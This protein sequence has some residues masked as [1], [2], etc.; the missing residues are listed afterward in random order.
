MKRTWVCPLSWD[1]KNAYDEADERLLMTLVSS[2]SVALE[3]ARLF[4]ETNRL[5]EDSRQ[6]TAELSL[7]NSVG[8]A[9][10]KQLQFDAIIDLVGDKV[11]DIF[12]A[13]TTYV[14]LYDPETKTI[15]IPYYVDRG[16]RIDVDPLPFG[17]GLT[18]IL[19][20]SKEPLVVG[21][22]QEMKE[23]GSVGSSEDVNESYLGVPIII[24]DEVTGALSVQSYQQ[25]AFDETHLRLLNTL[26]SSMSVALKNASLF[27]ETKHLLAET[28]ERA[29]ELSIINSVQEALASKLEVQ[30]IFD[31]V[32]DKIQEIFDAQVVT[33]STY[34]PKEDLVYSNYIIERGE[35][36][37]D[38]PRP[39]GGFGKELLEKRAPIMI[40]EN[41][42][43]E[44][45]KIGAKVTVGE[46]TKSWLGVPLMIGDEVRGG[47]SLQN[48][49]HENAFDDADQ[50]LLLTLASSMSVALEN[51]RLFDETTRL[52]DEAEER[53]NELS[54]INSVGQALASKLDIQAVFDLVGDKIQ[55]IFDAQVVMI[56]TYNPE[57]D[58]LHH[59]YTI[60][61]GERYEIEPIKPVGFAAHVLK[62]HEPLMVNENVA[63][64][65][66]ELGSITHAG[67]PT[68][69]LLNVPLMIG[70]EVRGVI[71]LQNVDR[72]HAFDDAD[73]RLL[74]TL[75]SSMSVALENARLFDET[76]RLLDESEQ[77]ASE[78]SIINSVGQALASQ[79]EIQAVFDLVGDK[80]YEI[81]DAQVVALMTYDRDNELMHYPYILERGE[82]LKSDP[83]PF[84]ESGFSSYIIRERQPLMF[85]TDLKEHMTEYGS[86]V[87]A[88]EVPQAF[89]GVPLMIGSEAKG[90]ISLQNLDHENAFSESDKRLLLTLASS[91]SVALENARLFAETTRRASEMAALSNIGREIS[92]TLDLPTVL[93]RITE[94]AGEVL[95]AKTSAVVLLEPDGETMRAISAV[96]EVANEIKAFSW[97]MG[98]GMIGSIAQSGVAERIENTTKDPRGV[99]IAGTDEEDDA[100]R[101]MV[102]P[103]FSD[104]QVIGAMAV[105]RAGDAEVFAQEELNFLVGLS[106]QAEIAIQNARLFEEAQR[107]A[108]ENA[109]LNEIGREISATLDLPT[110]LERIS[111]SVRDLLEADT[112]AVF[113]IEEDHRT[114]KAIAAVGKIAKQVRKIKP[115]LDNSVVGSIAQN[116]VPEVLNDI[117]DDPRTM[118]IPGTS[119]KNVGKKLMGAPLF[120]KGEVLGV[121]A[122]WRDENR[123]LFTE[124]DL[125]LLVGIS[126]QAAIAIQNAR[127][128]EESEKRADEMG[129]LT[130]IGREISETL[131]LPTVLERIATHAKDVLQAR[132][133]VLR[134]IEPDGTLPAVVALGKYAKFYKDNTLQ[135]GQGITGNVAKSGVAEIVNFPLEDWG[136]DS[137]ARPR[138]ERSLRAI[139]FGFCSGACSPGCNCRRERA[140]VPGGTGTT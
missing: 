117:G 128:F 58:L 103:L 24:G 113:E 44:A 68:E 86:Q 28:E 82:R 31:L 131:D 92:S 73:L 26:A 63:D 66:K 62:T 106:K 11:R 100:E 23:M 43:A 81:F 57:E 133:V 70:D 61:R 18:S 89:L 67:D 53:A 72:Q 16:R 17:T 116:G 60:E 1:K 40:N 46:P 109:A 104:E 129:A 76:T 125:E 99:H 84:G 107:Q 139:R 115:A 126:R 52:L 38:E 3:N 25:H 138:R 37:E 34:D 101:L 42:A 20:K 123:P 95:R 112:S 51:A 80:I 88:G 35:R 47:I 21:T 59:P 119:K 71:S 69:S 41:L 132:D 13:D 85:N 32:G 134:M 137:V 74:V 135:S 14:A 110:V 7:I 136:F 10:A 36:F 9:L 75:A 6:R 19:L 29:A 87:I 118:H 98:E 5:L 127:L 56:M 30:A 120:A 79:L 48:I 94:N 77:R 105:W 22:K 15:P 97:K 124:S 78:L 102:S 140:A 2:M 54:I 111:T 108:I 83:L 45:K 50:R 122:V 91:L 49:D 4:D 64:L 27:D 114:L 12:G 33:I 8:T 65:G 90:V 96:G 93:E 55:G 130:E 121:M 39:P